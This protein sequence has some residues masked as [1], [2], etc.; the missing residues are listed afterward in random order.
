MGLAAAA[1]RGHLD[2]VACRL[3]AGPAVGVV[4]CVAAAALALTARGW[5]ELD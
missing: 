4:D 1:A 5:R 3:Q 2:L